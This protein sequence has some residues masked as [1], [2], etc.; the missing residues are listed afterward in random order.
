M[1]KFLLIAF[2]LTIAQATSLKGSEVPSFVEVKYITNAGSGCSPSSMNA[3]VDTSA[4]TILHPSIIVT[5]GSGI[6]LTESRKNCQINFQL[7]YEKGWQYRLSN[8]KNIGSYNMEES[9]FS[10][11]KVTQ[12]AAGQLQ[13][14]TVEDTYKPG[15][16]DYI[17]DKTFAPSFL[18]SNCQQ[19]YST[20]LNS[21]GIR[22]SGQLTVG[23]DN[24]LFSLGLEWRRC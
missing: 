4:V 5:M 12:Y 3:T 2:F 15:T 8:F 14:V 10:S 18:W 20:N 22:N 13:Y 16:A 9:I 7:Q 24:V 6:P 19:N 1:N 23:K 11:F 17:F 21:Q